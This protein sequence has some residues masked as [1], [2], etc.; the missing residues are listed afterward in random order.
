EI[1]AVHVRDL[2]LAARRG[3]EPGCD[4][5][6]VGIVEVETGHGIARLRLL[7]LLLDAERAAAFVEFDDAV[8]VR[9]VHRIGENGGTVLSLDP[10]HHERPEIVPKKN[11]VAQD[12]GNAVAADEVAAND[13]GL[14]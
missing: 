2:E 5:Y 3:L 10:A 4:I 7:R 1:D 6:D 12:E 8:A 9:V 14:R 11:V 13:E